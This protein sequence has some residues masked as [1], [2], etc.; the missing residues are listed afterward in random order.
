MT[1]REE[2]VRE[3]YSLRDPIHRIAEP[4]ELTFGNSACPLPGRLRTEGTMESPR[5][6]WGL[7]DG[8]DDVPDVHSV[9]EQV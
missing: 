7:G 9:D 4:A 8:V 1:G 3:T 2:L 5:A 6:S